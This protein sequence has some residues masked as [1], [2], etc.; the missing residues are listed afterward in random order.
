MKPGTFHSSISHPKK[1][2]P[3]FYQNFADSRIRV[4]GRFVKKEDQAAMILSMRLNAMKDEKDSE[5]ENKTER[6]VASP[7]DTEEDTYM[8]ADEVDDAMR[9]AETD[10]CNSSFEHQSHQ[11]LETAKTS[12]GADD[13]E[14]DEEE[15]PECDS[16]LNAVSMSVSST[17]QAEKISRPQG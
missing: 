13:E 4:K 10:D 15:D 14:E 6:S 2:L 16:P 12:D 7:A 3:V 11:R 5:M 8:D 17:A 9:T 1:I